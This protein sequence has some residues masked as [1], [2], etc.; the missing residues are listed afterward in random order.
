MDNDQVKI[1]FRVPGERDSV[2]VTLFDLI[3][4][5]SGIEPDEWQKGAFVR[6]DALGSHI[7]FDVEAP[8]VE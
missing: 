1:T 8:I 3:N 4:A 6:V 2:E 5:A 7:V